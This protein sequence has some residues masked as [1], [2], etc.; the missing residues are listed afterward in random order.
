MQLV[1]KVYKEKR[2]GQSFELAFPM[3]SPDDVDRVYKELVT[4]GATAVKESEMMPWGRK[5]AFIADPD[6]SIHEIYS[7]KPEDFAREE[8]DEACRIPSIAF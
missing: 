1:T 5:T 6:G 4:K 8:R 2:K 7:Y 3:G